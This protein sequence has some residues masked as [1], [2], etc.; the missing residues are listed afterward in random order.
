MTL[1]MRKNRTSYNSVPLAPAY[2]ALYW[3]TP[4]HSWADIK[5]AEV[6]FGPKG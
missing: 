5:Y 3:V 6:H 2:S 4:L 1:L